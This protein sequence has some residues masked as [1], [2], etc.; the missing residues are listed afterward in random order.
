[1]AVNIKT[2]TNIKLPKNSIKYILFQRTSYLKN[3]ISFRF[4]T[5]LGYFKSF[6]KLSVNLKSFFFSSA[7]KSEFSRDM[8]SEYSKL[9]QHLPQDANS[10]LD[11]G[12]GV[13]GVDVFISNH[14]NNKINIF[15]VD[16]TEIDKNVYYHYEKRGSFY[17]S[18]NI[19]KSLLE[20]N[21]IDSHK[22]NLQEATENN[23]ISFEKKFDIV[24]SLISWGFHYP[25]S[26]YLDEV[27]NKMNKN[28][29]LILDVRKNTNGEKDIEK[30]FGNHQI[31]FETGK[32]MRILAKKNN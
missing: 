13:A 5:Y 18:L 29:I 25:V 6:Y 28:G 7:I 22:I 14:Y 11:I 24:I 26:T 4:L 30:R 15:L 3:N 17:N 12:C 10:V 8:E 27:Y 9:K 2:M 23:K 16:K 19:A 31:I 32:Y 20:I 21:G 1:M